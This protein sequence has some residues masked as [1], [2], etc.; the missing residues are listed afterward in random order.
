MKKNKSERWRKRIFY[1]R[2]TVSWLVGTNKKRKIW[3]VSFDNAVSLQYEP[4]CFYPAQNQIAKET[5][6]KK[7]KKKKKNK[8]VCRY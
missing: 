1:P 2:F 3:V 8:G 7:K 6:K 5:N 4:N